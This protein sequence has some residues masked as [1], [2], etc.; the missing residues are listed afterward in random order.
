[1]TRLLQLEKHE[2]AIYHGNNRGNVCASIFLGDDDRARFLEVLGDVIKRY[3]W[4][5]L[6]TEDPFNNPGASS[7]LCRTGAHAA[8]LFYPISSMVKGFPCPG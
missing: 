2:G 3:H 8:V 1:M 7:T 6:R 5:C 4:I